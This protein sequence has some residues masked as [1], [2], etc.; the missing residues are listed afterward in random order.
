LRR[1]GTAPTSR[2][3]CERNAMPSCPE[4]DVALRLEPARWK[5]INKL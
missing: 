1:C 4:Y 2:R 5:A 3:S